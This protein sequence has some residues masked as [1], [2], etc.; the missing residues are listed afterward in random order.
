MVDAMSHDNARIIPF[1]KHKGRLIDEVLVDDPIYVEW[2]TSQEWFRSRFTIL[3]QVVINRGADSAETPEH[4]AMQVRFL[5]RDFCQQFLRRIAPELVNPVPF[6]VVFEEYGVDVAFIF[7]GNALP[8]AA[9]KRSLFR[10]AEPYGSPRLRIELKP[11]MS[12]DYPAVLRQMRAN[13]SNVLFVGEYTGRGAS[14]RQMI[15][16]FA[17]SD[18]YVVFLRDFGR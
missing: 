5:D 11:T 12:D 13:G 2:L 1:G 17:A 15:D 10:Y 3:Y 6:D 18:I 8:E 4:N 16:T 14:E 9:H 7:T